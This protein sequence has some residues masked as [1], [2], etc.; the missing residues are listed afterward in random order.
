[1]V[2]AD[3]CCQLIGCGPK[4]NQW[5][6][7]FQ[8]TQWKYA[9]AGPSHNRKRFPATGPLGSTFVIHPPP[10]LT[11]NQTPVRPP[12]TPNPECRVTQSPETFTSLQSMEIKAT[13]SEPENSETPNYNFNT[14]PVISREIPM[15]KPEA[16]EEM[17]EAD[18]TTERAWNPRSKKGRRPPTENSSTVMIS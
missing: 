8:A 3:H 5:P 17:I 7:T 11:G 16:N 9:H 4:Y 14:T 1:M 18:A 10:V 15:A 12:T 2:Q 13:Q 6:T